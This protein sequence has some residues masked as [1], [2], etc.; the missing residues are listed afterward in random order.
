MLAICGCSDAAHAGSEKTVLLRRS[1]QPQ[2]APS[3]QLWRAGHPARSSV[4]RRRAERLRGA[5]LK[6]VCRERQGGCR[7]NASMWDA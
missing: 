6:G 2:Q 3:R 4:D 7:P 5:G 1:P